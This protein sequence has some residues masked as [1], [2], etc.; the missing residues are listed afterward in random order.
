MPTLKA[1]K[2][3]KE[4]P[5]DDFLDTFYE[6]DHPFEFI[7]K[8]EKYKEYLNVIR[9]TWGMKSIEDSDTIKYDGIKTK[10][11]K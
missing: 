5:I 6:E 2:K 7:Y 11:R 9:R 8:T 1:V 4:M 10:S 3:L